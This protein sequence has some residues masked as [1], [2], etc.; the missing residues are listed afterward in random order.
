[1]NK[2]RPISSVILH[3]AVIAI[4]LATSAS[5]TNYKWYGAVSGDWNDIGNWD[6]TGIPA[7]DATNG[8]TNVLY[9]A[10]NGANP[11]TF[12]EANGTMWCNTFQINDGDFV[13]NGGTLIVTNSNSTVSR[14]GAFGSGGTMTVNSG[15][16]T[17]ATWDTLYISEN[18]NKP[19]TL[20]HQRTRL[21]E[22]LSVFHA[23]GTRR[24]ACHPP[25]STAERWQIDQPSPVQVGG[26]NTFQ[27][28]R[29]G[30]VEGRRL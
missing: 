5:A 11:L 19:C 14:I 1:M 12:S 24:R 13:F 27:F 30:H 21:I 17:F 23:G 15:R 6:A 10:N 28:Q 7:L 26:T 25:I 18:G 29:R 3:A 2:M 8:A 9:V 20:N 4:G 22:V 16:I